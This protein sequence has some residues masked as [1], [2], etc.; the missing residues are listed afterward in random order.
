MELSAWRHPEVG[1]KEMGSGGGGEV[2][3]EMQRSKNAVKESCVASSAS[4]ADIRSLVTVRVGPS[5]PVD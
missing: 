4:V 5:E 1:R 2:L 3:T